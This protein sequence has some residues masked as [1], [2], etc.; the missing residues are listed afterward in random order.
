MKRTS[1]IFSF[2]FLLFACK[3]KEAMPPTPFG[4]VPSQRQLAWHD[5]E[6]YAFVHFNMN[7]FTNEEWGH[8]T[9]NP[10]TFNP[11]QLDCEQ[12][13]RICKQAGMKGIILTVKHH[14]GFCL[15]PSKYTEHS[16]K[17][18]TW[19]NGQGDVVKELSEA[20]KKYGLKM[21]VYLSPWDRN[22]PT[23]GTPEYN[24]VFKNT[25]KEV[26]TSYGDI[27]E[28]WFDGANGEGPNGKKQEYDWKGFIEVVRT[29]QPNACIFSDG[30][31]DV[32]WVGNENGFANPT[33][34]G[35]LNGDKVYPGYPQYKEL[36]SG[37]E[38]GT[39]WIPAECDVSIRPGWYYHA[40]Q[41]DK[42][43]TLPQLVEI[44]FSS[45]GRNANLLLNLPV[46]RR[47]LVHEND[48]I[49]LVKLRKYLDESFANNLAKGTSVIASAY[50]AND[51]NFDGNK[52]T[53]GDPKTY[54]ATDDQVTT[55]S[56]EIDLQKEKP[57][58]TLVIQEFITLG[59]RVKSFSIEVWKNNAWEKVAQETTIGNKRIV[60]LPDISTS[61]IK[62][63]ILESKAC[64]LISNVE[65][66]K[67]SEAK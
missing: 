40:D 25:L 14:D 46:D 10:N 44:Y 9:E 35:T 13:A 28:V 31:P 20:C 2:L 11:T 32:R 33:N 45:V 19:K 34:W 22:H 56:L 50:R 51:D 55:G 66:Y 65:L 24:E 16:V 15:F 23:Y 39:H 27:F 43:K 7:T 54:W 58:N 57:I 21:G 5:L 30:G 61:K 53:D 36:T 1:L 60:N 12:W 17:N 63:N 18:S 4:A 38:D 26:L 29:Y 41:D 3:D 67:I 8:G 6:Y 42:V 48:S 52:V 64:P 37:H 59:Q 49:A 62:I 47:G